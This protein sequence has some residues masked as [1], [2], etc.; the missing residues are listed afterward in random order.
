MDHNFKAAAYSRFKTDCD[1]GSYHN[2]DA[3]LNCHF[4][5]Q[6]S[7]LGGCHD[8]FFLAKE[9]ETNHHKKCNLKV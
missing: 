3:W 9:S 8:Y 7:T 4:P 5:V 2:N 1:P 6:E